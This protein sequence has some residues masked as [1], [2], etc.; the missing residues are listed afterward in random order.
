MSIAI[1]INK[2]KDV[3]FSKKIIRHKMK[4]IQ[5]KK[6]KLET[7]EINKIFLSSFD[8]K[9][10]VR[11]LIFIKIRLQVVERF[12]KIVKRLKKIVII[13]KDCDN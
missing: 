10:F 9:R 3:L 7:Y 5:S 12:K 11:R 1:E 13:E 2:F 4:R 8:N 6:H